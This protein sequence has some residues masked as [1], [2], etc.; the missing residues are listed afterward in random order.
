MKPRKHLPFIR[1][2][3]SF[4][5]L[6][7]KQILM[8]E[9]AAKTLSID[10][11][12]WLLNAGQYCDGAYFLLNGMIRTAVTEDD[13]DI[14]VWITL[15]CQF[16]ISSASYRQN[17]P[18]TVGLQAVAKSK[19]LWF[20]SADIKM[21]HQ[22]IPQ[23]KDIALSILREHYLQL[24]R[25]YTFC[26]ARSA[27]KRYLNFYAHFPELFFKIPLKFLAS[28]IHVQPETLSRIRRRQQDSGD[29]PLP[30][31]GRA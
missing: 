17:E 29:L 24:E 28:M 13:E 18:S 15:P 20:S 22:N 14:T 27:T 30:V 6:D 3:L 31:T 23:L 12:N 21:L 26:L 19:L 5:S 8:I 16:I 25:L 11:N 10:K 9:A 7:Q 4:A 2:L 1:Y